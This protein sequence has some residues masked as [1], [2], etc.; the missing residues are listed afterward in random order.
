MPLALVQLWGRGLLGP[1][2]GEGQPERTRDDDFSAKRVRFQTRKKSRQSI[3]PPKNTPPRGGTFLFV[4]GVGV[5]G[6][7]VSLSAF[8]TLLHSLLTGRRKQQLHFPSQELPWSWGDQDKQDMA[9]ALENEEKR[10]SCGR[11]CAQ[12]EPRILQKGP[13]NFKPLT[14]LP[15]PPLS[16]A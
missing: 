4:W 16:S 1:P 5:G 2:R 11:G 7:K 12:V 3:L 6:V 14:H 8:Y 9:P 10:W 13:E 15:P